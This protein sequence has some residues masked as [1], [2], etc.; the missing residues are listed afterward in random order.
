MGYDSSN[1]N[2]YGEFSVAGCKN[3]SLFK[4]IK[5]FNQTSLAKEHNF[6]NKSNFKLVIVALI[7]CLILIVWYIK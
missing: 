2:H 1:P 7:G 3:G 6:L 4:A 5:K